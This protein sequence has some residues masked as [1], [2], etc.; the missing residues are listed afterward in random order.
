MLRTVLSAALAAAALSHVPAQAANSVNG[1]QP[2]GLYT[3]GLYTNGFVV[4]G[5]Y[6]N[7]F[8][9]NGMKSNGTGLRTPSAALPQVESI[10]LRDGRKLAVR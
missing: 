7:G 8:V 6:T 1:T 3:N 9:V 10:V 2:N 5:L 4:N